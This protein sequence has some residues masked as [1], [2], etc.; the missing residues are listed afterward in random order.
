VRRPDAFRRHDS[1]SIAAGCAL[2]ALV[3]L[4]LYRREAGRR[5]TR[6]TGWELDDD[7][8]STALVRFPSLRGLAPIIW[9]C[10]A[11]RVGDIRDAEHPRGEAQRSFQ[12]PGGLVQKNPPGRCP[13]CGLG[14]PIWGRDLW[15][16]RSRVSAFEE[17][18]TESARST[19]IA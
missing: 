5:P 15:L 2:R 8:T 18:R 10:C 19:G 12:G 17:V 13:N 16:A 14:E 1:G 11:L 7:A 9:R 6:R 4:I 3:Q